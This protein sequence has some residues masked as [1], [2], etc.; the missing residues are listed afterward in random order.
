MATHGEDATAVGDQAMARTREHWMV[1]GV[2]AA[3]VVAL[4]LLAFVLEPDPRGFGTHEQLGLQPCM[5][6]ELWNF[7]CPGCGVT[8][9]TALALQGHVGA[10]LRNQP[11][12][13]VCAAGGLLFVAWALVA[14]LFGR[15]LGNDVRRLP[16]AKLVA[17]G[18]FVLCVCWVYKLALVRGIF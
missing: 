12:G 14:L 15:D 11:F 2:A 17:A 5:P 18:A 1:V 10:S 4:G 3:S 9:S 6:M 16:F 13:V 8:T 7:P